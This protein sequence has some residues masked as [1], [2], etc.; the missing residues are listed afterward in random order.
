ME[1]GARVDRESIR[2]P[3]YLF[4]THS[5]LHRNGSFELSTFSAA[6]SEGATGRDNGEITEIP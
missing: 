5:L 4:V 2:S 1:L 6:E 3:L